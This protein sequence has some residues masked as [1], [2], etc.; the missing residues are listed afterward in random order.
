MLKKPSLIL[1][2]FISF[3][4]LYCHFTLPKYDSAESSRDLNYDA[5]SYYLYLPMT[6]IY[7]DPGMKTK[8]VDS[9][10]VK[11]NFSPTLY[12][13]HTTENNTRVPNYTAGMSYFYLPGFLIANAWAKNSDYPQD[14][15]S[16]PYQKAIPLLIYFLAI[17][18]IF[19][20]RKLLLEWFSEKIVSITLILL[21][22]GTN[23]FSEAIGNTLQPHVAM[24][25][26][27]VL[28]LFCIH[29]WHLFPSFKYAAIG[30][31]AAGL[32]TLTRPT[33]IICF[34]IPLLWNVYDKK[35]FRK[36]LKLFSEH[37]THILVLIIFAFL[38]FIPQFLYWKET[39]GHFIYFSYKHTEGFD[40]TE[41]HILQVLFSFKKSL[42]V[43][44]PLLLVAVFGMFRMKKYVP[45]LTYPVIIF[46]LL[47]FYLL[48]SWAVWWN[49]ASFGMRYFVQSYVLLT[50]PIAVAVQEFFR[51]KYLKFILAPVI[52]FLIFLN[53][54]QTWQY[55]H[56][57]LPE[58]RMTYK[59]YKASFLKTRVTDEEWKLMEVYRDKSYHE[60]FNNES[61]YIHYTIAY[62]DFENINS[63]AIDSHIVSKKYSLSPPNSYRLS[64]DYIYNPTYRIRYDHLVKEK[65]DHVW[66]RLTVSYFSETDIRDNQTF[67]VMNFM[68]KNFY[69]KYS[70]TDLRNFPFE[71]GKWNT[72]SVEYMTPYPYSKKD[73]FEFYMWYRGNS[74]IFIDN[75]KLEVFEKKEQLESY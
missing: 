39:T 29:K 75:F 25:S 22:L 63:T 46:I 40:F 72:A 69:H 11:Y 64:P 3:L 41:P 61:E 32:L 71:K 35:S 42:L 36:K 38:P 14:G 44:T 65:L 73:K 30:G 26:M 37:K 24:F 62:Y 74:E 59:Y 12:Q 33:D 52:C 68:H 20:L 21:C 10:K 4:I 70:A 47:N 31:F 18:G 50:I 27:Y 66:L 45:G 13:I 49:G 15:F 8:T 2:I 23:Y 58:D 67:I 17:P 1:A 6:F 16:L 48:S 60:T 34:I 57:L 54:F 43:Y 51:I 19:L 5:V 7:H 56:W 9:L 53:L 28:L 55:V